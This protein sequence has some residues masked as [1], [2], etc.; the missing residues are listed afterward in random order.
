[1]GSIRRQLM[2]RLALILAA[3]GLLL[4]LATYQF[5]R[6]E[7]S[8]VFDEQLKQLAISVRTHYRGGGSTL[9]A[10]P[11]NAADLEDSGMVTQIWT[12]DRQRV[13][14]SDPAADIPWVDEEGYHT[15]ATRQGAWRVYAERS[16]THLIQAAQLMAVREELAVDT[17][18]EI[19]LPNLVVVL[20]LTALLLAYALQ[21]SLAPLMQTATDI[22]RR[23]ANSLDP[24][25]TTAL[26][27][28]L[29][30]LVASI[31]ALMA[32]LATALSAQRRFTADAAHELRTPLSA[33]RLQLQLLAKA[34]NDASRQEALIDIQRGLDR[35]TRLVEQL[36]HLAR[37][38]PDT[39]E[40][41]FSSVDLAALTKSVVTDF[42]VLAN[43]RGIDLGAEIDA[44]ES[45]V[46]GDAQHLRMLLDNLVDNALRYTPRGGKVDVVL[47]AAS[48]AVLLEVADSGPG[49]TPEEQARVFDRFYRGTSAHGAD[50]ATSGT[51]LGLAIVKEITQRHGARIDLLDGLPSPDGTRG[52]TVRVTFDSQKTTRIATA[53]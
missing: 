30:P 14:L 49:I 25:T 20:A 37:L 21:R 9:L 8:E 36:L 11:G 26:P 52:L 46:P 50:G 53:P 44:V 23:S 42:S 18:V 31:N 39:I 7:M 15:L 24:I 45:W 38:E 51:G 19:L 29:K 35:A 16:P 3:G 6:Q 34:T 1:M 28:E 47:R 2:V 17:A 43:A 27:A 32:R 48:Q 41:P 4:G 5:T 22:G 12:L 10:T 33:L 13:F 40:R